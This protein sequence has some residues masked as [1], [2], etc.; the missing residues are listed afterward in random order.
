METVYQ[1]VHTFH[2]SKTAKPYFRG[3]GMGGEGSKSNG[4][5]IPEINQDLIFIP[6]PATIQ[7]I[8]Y[9]KMLSLIKNLRSCIIAQNYVY[10]NYNNSFSLSLL[11]CIQI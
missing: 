10:K 1:G 5:E 7:H 3:D 9:I 8:Y 11:N 2:P 4:A 6:T